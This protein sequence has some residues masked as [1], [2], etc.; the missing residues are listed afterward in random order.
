MISCDDTS[1]LR[2]V[3]VEVPAWVKAGE[4]V[5][6]ECHFNLEALDT[7]YSLTWWR[8]QRQFYK[9][10]PTTPNRKAKYHLEGI[11]VDVS[12]SG[13]NVVVLKNVSVA[14]A[15]NFKCEVVA[16]SPSFEKDAKSA[17][18]RVVEVPSR[19]P[20]VSVGASDGEGL[21]LANCTSP[22]ASPPPQL[23]WLLNGRQ[24]PSLYS[25]VLTGPLGEETP[26]SLL[27]LPLSEV[28][29]E[30]GR[31]LLTCRAALLPVYQQATDVLL[32]GRKH[33]AP[34]QKLYGADR[35]QAAILSLLGAACHLL[36]PTKDT[37][38]I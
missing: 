33:V 16:D 18:M 23:H 6:L 26:T 24:L 3:R 5:Q 32:R 22:G 2:I 9:F 28:R 8:G 36:P 21:L 20:V 30:G 12:R 19:V 7:L 13:L 4:T 29:E 37:E 25:E 17:L 11:W 1:C 35:H 15:G 27:R 10:S 31:L 38:P 14:T 34:S